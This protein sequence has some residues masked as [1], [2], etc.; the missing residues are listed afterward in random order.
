MRTVV[1]RFSNIYGPGDDFEP[2]SAHL[3]GNTIRLVANDEPPEIW[4]DGSQLRAYLY[5]ASAIEAVLFLVE[6]G[7]EQGPINIGGQAEY[8]VK[9]IIELIIEISGKPLNPILHPEYPTG[10]DRK[11][12]DVTRFRR[13]TGLDESVSLKEGLQQTYAWYLASRRYQRPQSCQQGT[14]G[15]P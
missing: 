6:A 9:D 7:T 10:I 11:L 8:S 12:L 1:A 2:E 3:I 15:Q 13:M 5:V 4:G 14:P